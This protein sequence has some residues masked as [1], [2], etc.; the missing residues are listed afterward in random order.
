MLPPAEPLAP[1]AGD[2]PPAPTVT[3][4]EDGSKLAATGPMIRSA[5]PPPPPPLPLEATVPPAPPD[6]P[7]ATRYAVQK[8]APV[9]FVQV[10]PGVVNDW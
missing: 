2:A 7:P 10:P 3:V 4:A 1:D 5:P 6:P 9:G 8:V